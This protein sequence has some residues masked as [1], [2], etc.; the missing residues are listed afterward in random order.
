MG[1]LKFEKFLNE[2]VVW[3]NN[4]D[5]LFVFVNK[6][7]RIQ[8]TPEE[9][10]IA[11]KEILNRMK[12]QQNVIFIRRKMIDITLSPFGKTLK[13][14]FDGKEY[15]ISS[16]VPDEVWNIGARE[17]PLNPIKDWEMRIKLREV[18]I[19]YF[20]ENIDENLNEDEIIF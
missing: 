15:D 9:I 13:F 18:F 4:R 6:G 3:A 8:K 20:K 17:F 5:S 2:L 11:F 14:S 19:K 12:T 7:I 10:G 16:E 1:K